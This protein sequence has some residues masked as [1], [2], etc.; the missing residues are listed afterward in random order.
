MERVKGKKGDITIIFLTVNLVPKKWAEYQKEVLLEAAAGAP[1]IT[2]SKKPLKWGDENVIQKEKICATSIY[3]NVLKGAKMAKT[4]FIGIAEDDALYPEEHYYAFRPKDAFAYNKTRWGIFSWG[5]PTY[6]WRER[7]SNMAMIAPRELAIEAL[8][9]RFAKDAQSWG[10]LGNWR[11][12]KRL[13][14]TIRRDVAFHTTIPIVY[15]HHEKGLDPHERTRRKRMSMVRAFDI[16][17]W[18]RAEELRKKFV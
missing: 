11:L 14:I 13:G 8:E 17:H 1:I 5:K 2:F 4:P 10:E 16:P 15:F 9:E 12:E 6:F 3:R 18:G 7:R